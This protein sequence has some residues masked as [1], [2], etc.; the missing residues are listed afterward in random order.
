[1]VSLV[2]NARGLLSWVA[3][4]SVVAATLVLDVRVP[5]SREQRDAL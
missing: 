5:R 1:M 4:F 2:L 3:T